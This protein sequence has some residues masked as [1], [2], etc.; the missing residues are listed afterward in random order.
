MC[1]EQRHTPSDAE[2][3][4]SPVRK[5]PNWDRPPRSEN[6]DAFHHGSASALWKT[7]LRHRAKYL[8]HLQM[9]VIGGS[10]LTSYLVDAAMQVG[11]DKAGRP[12]TPSSGFPCKVLLGFFKVLLDLSRRAGVSGT[13]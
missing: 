1:F 11:Y 7:S 12:T 5:G 3:V 4:S 9:W 10:R 13:F 6:Q 8:A 2:S